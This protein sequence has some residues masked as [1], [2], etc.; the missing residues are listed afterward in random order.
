MDDLDAGMADKGDA[1][2]H[3]MIRFRAATTT[4][5]LGMLLA[6]ATATAQSPATAKGEVSMH[7][8]SG[9]FEVKM[10]PQKADNPQ[11]EAAGLGRMSIDKQF[12]GA[13]EATSQG[14][15]LSFLD[16]EKGSGGY[17]AL[18]RVSGTLEGKTGTFVLQHNATMNR[19]V[20]AM[21]I[22]VVPDSGT[23]DLT[24][25]SG[26]MKIRIEE[27]GKHFYDFEYTLA[28]K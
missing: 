2:L 12:H 13:L 25:I 20:P 21:N 9:P 22:N 24:G 16:R 26:S 23:G 3:R 6:L 15:M 7:Q 19:G 18:E 8:I 28:T 17:V 11:A 10:A 27:G 1:M 4:V 14:E 5:G